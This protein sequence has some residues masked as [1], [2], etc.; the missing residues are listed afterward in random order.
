MRGCRARFT[1]WSAFFD[2]P[3]PFEPEAHDWVSQKLEWL[4][5]RDDLPRYQESGKPR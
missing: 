5:I 1:S 3:E 4:D 2:D